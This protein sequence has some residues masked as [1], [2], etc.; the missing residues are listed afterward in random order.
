MIN[1]LRLPRFCFISFC[2]FT[3]FHLPF[4]CFFI[5]IKNG[6]GIYWYRI[7][8]NITQKP[9]IYCYISTPWFFSIIHVFRYIYCW[10]IDLLVIFL[11]WLHFHVQIY[12]PHLD[13]A[14]PRWVHFAHGLLLF[15]YQ[16]CS[17]ILY[18]VLLYSLDGMSSLE[19]WT[20]PRDFMDTIS[21]LLIAL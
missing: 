19:S 6:L 14:P 12:S 3:Y 11:F 8:A 15:L 21:M 13:S 9:Y 10:F 18:E 16:V 20:T 17:N 4:C 5:S 2:A 1:A 7:W